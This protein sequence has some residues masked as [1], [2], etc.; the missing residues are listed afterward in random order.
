[1]L[2]FRSAQFFG[3]QFSGAQFS[4]C[5]V[6]PVPTFPTAQFFGAQFSGAYISSAKF[7]VYLPYTVYA[8]LQVTE[9]AFCFAS[10]LSYRRAVLPPPLL[11]KG[12]GGSC[13][14]R[15]GTTVHI[16]PGGLFPNLTKAVRNKEKGMREKIRHYVYV[17]VQ[18]L[19]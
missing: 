14:S 11:A 4:R 13:P 17:R 7:S 6:F 18:T 15:S 10:L 5:P 16:H 2:S 12:Q 3:A 1:M 19:G 8:H 9:Q